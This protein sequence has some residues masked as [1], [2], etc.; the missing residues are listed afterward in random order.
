MCALPGPWQ[1]SHPLSAAGARVLRLAMRGPIHARTLGFV[2][3]DARVLADVRARLDWN[4]R[5]HGEI[6]NRIPEGDGVTPAPGAIFIAR[7][8]YRIPLAYARG[9]EGL[10]PRLGRAS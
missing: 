5:G 2:A 3:A 4:S 9:S 8:P 1:L 6:Q 7:M 10:F